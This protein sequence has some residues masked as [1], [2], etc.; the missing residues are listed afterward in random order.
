MRIVIDNKLVKKL[1]YD[2]FTN[3]KNQFIDIILNLILGITFS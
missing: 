3:R 2:R 1:T